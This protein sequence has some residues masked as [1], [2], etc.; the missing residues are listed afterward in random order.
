MT[1]RL[2]IVDD[3]PDHCANLSDFCEE[4]GWETRTACSAD[5]AERLLA[6]EAFS[7][8]V[9]DVTMPG[10]DGVSYCRR[11]RARAE[12]IP[13]LMLTANTLTEERVEGLHA[14]ADDYLGKPF[15]FAEFEARVCAVLRRAPAEKLIVGD[16][17]YDVRQRRAVR[18]GKPLRLRG[19]ALR[20]LEELMK[21]SPNV[22]TRETLTA[23]LWPEGDVPQADSLRAN[24]HLLRG[25][26]DRPFAGALIR[27][28]PGV[29]WSID[30]AGPANK[31]DR[32]AP[33]AHGLPALTASSS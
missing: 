20:I 2:L 13:V 18:A 32:Q 6:A 29:G 21:A 19:L 14:G 15:S 16:L 5:D 4:I 25:V 9:L 11:L 17:V 3:D 28:H 23:A 33:A 10:L 12:M 24:M 1:T 26:V 8:M 30:R 27:T 31:S 22:V 7:L